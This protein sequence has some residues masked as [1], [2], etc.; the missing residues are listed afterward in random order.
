ME[1]LNFEI[2]RHKS[3]LISYTDIAT[4][5]NKKLL[6]N[7]RHITTQHSYN[8]NPSTDTGLHNINNTSATGFNQKQTP[9]WTVV[10]DKYLRIYIKSL[11]NIHINIPNTITKS[12]ANY[13]KGGKAYTFRNNTFTPHVHLRHTYSIK[14]IQLTT[15]ANNITHTTIPTHHSHLD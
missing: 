6:S 12:I 14:H 1:I 11:T 2:H 9:A 4:C 13:S 7:I 10:L 8:R 3:F 5:H 15:Y